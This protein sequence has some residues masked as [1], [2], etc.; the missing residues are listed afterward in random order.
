EGGNTIANGVN[1]TVN[2]S[3]GVH[4][5]TLTVTDD[6][7]ATDTDQVVVTVNAQSQGDAVLSFTLINAGTDQPIAAFDPIPDGATLSLSTLP[8]NL[9]IRANTSPVTVGSV[10]FNMTGAQIKNI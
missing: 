5:I 4:T 7:N 8:S 2:L 1:P 10:V 6:D 3:V 9:N